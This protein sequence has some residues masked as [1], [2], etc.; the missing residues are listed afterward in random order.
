MYP[1]VVLF[2]FVAAIAYIARRRRHSVVLAAFFAAFL[3][4][5]SGTRFEVGCDYKGYSLRY[6]WLYSGMSWSDALRAGEGG[7]NWLN[8]ALLHFDL[9]YSALLFVCALIFAACLYRFARHAQR[10]L[11]M[12]VLAFPVLVVQLSMS[13]LRQAM[14]TAF[15]MVAL[16]AFIDRRRLAVLVW[17]AIAAL[18]HTSAVVFLPL[19]LLMGR[20]IS[21]LRM[22]GVLLVI[23]PVIALL[24]GERMEVYNDRYVAQIYGEQDSDGAWFRYAIVLIPFLVLLWKRRIVE[25]EFPDQFP[26]M[27]LFALFALSLMPAGLISSVLLHRFVFYIMPVSILAL[28]CISECVFKPGSKR[29]GALLPFLAYGAYI[30]VWFGYS[31]HGA[32]CYLPYQTWLLGSGM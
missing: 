21:T 32:S 10:P 18:F 5:F 23:S 28:L 3:V 22:F 20:N 24:L 14:A 6:S 16:G 1:Y 7:F 26:L 25:W 11:S 13:G 4:F 9:S 15:L 12:M 27:R 2:W 31:S 17:V 29:F 8:K 19:F 30:T